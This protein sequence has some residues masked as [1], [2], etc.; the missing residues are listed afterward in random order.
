ML[1]SLSCKGKALALCLFLIVQTN[2]GY[3]GHAVTF[4]LF[5]SFPE[6]QSLQVILHL[7]RSMT[8]ND[9]TEDA[10]RGKE[11]RHTLPIFTPL[12][13]WEKSHPKVLSLV[14]R[15]LGDKLT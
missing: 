2:G 15:R 4:S 11:A 6:D 13:P 9:F 5:L 7:V 10:W 3:K 12:T 14:L 8:E 1:P